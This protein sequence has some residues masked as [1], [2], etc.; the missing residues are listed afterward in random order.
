MSDCENSLHA[1]Y[2]YLDGELTD[3]RRAVI[4]HHLDECQP[5]AEPYDF[6]A[7]L[8]IVIRRKCAEQVPDTLLAK[9]K[10]ALEREAAGA[11]EA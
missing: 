11:S 3:D 2:S 8:R 4:Q 9:V 5:C 10:A 6:E 1:L 7:E